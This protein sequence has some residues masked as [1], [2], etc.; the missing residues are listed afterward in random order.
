MRRGIQDSVLLGVDSLENSELMRYADN[1]TLCALSDSFT[2]TTMYSSGH[3]FGR[4]TSTLTQKDRRFSSLGLS[5]IVMK[6]RII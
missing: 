3:L 6:V 1:S 5:R 4:M 2:W